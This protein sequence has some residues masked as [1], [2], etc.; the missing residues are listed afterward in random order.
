ML[1]ARRSF[2]DDSVLA[3]VTR[4]SDDH[5]LAHRWAERFEIAE[6]AR[7][8]ERSSYGGD[9]IRATN[10]INLAERTDA[11][12]AMQGYLAPFNQPTEINDPLEGHFIESFRAG[13]FTRTLR[14]DIG[15]VRVLF[16]HGRD[17][18][19]GMKPI[20][21]PDF[22]REDALGV[23][24]QARLLD[25]G[26]VRD[27]VLPGLEQGLYGVSC[28]FRKLLED[29]SPPR[30]GER[31]PRRVIREVKLREFGPVTFPAYPGTSVALAG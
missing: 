15:G 20:G 21:V 13:A 1:V 16:Q 12:P 10:A 14:E 4:V 8:H 17:G 2:A 27:L 30:R 18:Q 25:A 6:D 26:Y 22:V 11:L 31:L 7:E 9:C 29:V 24:F 5:P 19:V 28:R 3:G 23:A